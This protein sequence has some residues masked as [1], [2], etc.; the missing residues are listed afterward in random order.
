MTKATKEMSQEMIRH[1]K[2]IINAFEK[3]LEGVK[4]D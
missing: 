2:G 4:V 1:I 3:W